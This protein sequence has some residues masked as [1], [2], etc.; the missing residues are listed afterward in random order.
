MDKKVTRSLE[1]EAIA[2]VNLSKKYA[3]NQQEKKIALKVVEGDA[4]NTA[5]KVDDTITTEVDDASVELLDGNISM[6]SLLVTLKKRKLQYQVMEEEV[7][8]SDNG[9]T[10]DVDNAMLPSFRTVFQP[11]PKAADDM[12]TELVAPELK[13]KYRTGKCYNVRALKS[14]GDY[15]NLCNYHRLRANAN[16]RKLDRKKKEQRLQQQLTANAL[17]GA[18]SPRSV[19]QHSFLAAHAAAA[20]LASLVAA[21]PQHH[22]DVLQ[23]QRLLLASGAT[24]HEAGTSNRNRSN[25]ATNCV[26]PKQE[27]ACSY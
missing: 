3:S 2:L 7:A 14:C 8:G 15:H 1:Q 23:Q 5:I 6:N 10:D 9:S 20:A 24:V 26:S 19:K 21:Q 25:G 22:F 13:C 17:I 27:D 18:S 4:D 16:Q 12:S 11:Q